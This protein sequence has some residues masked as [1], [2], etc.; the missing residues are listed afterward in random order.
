ML[1]FA[2]TSHR[3]DTVTALPG[4]KPGPYIKPPRKV[5]KI[6]LKLEIH[7]IIKQTKNN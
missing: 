4:T 5:L 2:D 3:T 7:C 6:Q 1:V